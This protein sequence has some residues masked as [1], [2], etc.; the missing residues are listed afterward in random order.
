MQVIQEIDASRRT[1][2][3]MRARSNAVEDR[4]QA[5][6]AFSPVASARFTLVGKITLD[7][8]RPCHYE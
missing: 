2:D 7:V 6:V 8:E 3:R 4:E 1:F 5:S